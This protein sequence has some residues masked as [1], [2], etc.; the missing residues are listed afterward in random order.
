MFHCKIVFIT[1]PNMFLVLGIAN[2]KKQLQ[3]N[4]KFKAETLTPNQN[5]KSGKKTPIKPAVID[6]AGDAKSGKPGK[7]YF[8]IN[9]CLVVQYSRTSVNHPS[10]IIWNSDEQPCYW[11]S[12]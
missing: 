1:F 5:N 6:L 2:I 8:L 7:I 12:S 9:V 3:N 11:F 4:K 10:F